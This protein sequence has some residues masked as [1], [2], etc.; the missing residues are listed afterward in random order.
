MNNRVSSGGAT[1]VSG[2]HWSRGGRE[3]SLVFSGTGSVKL[4][5]QEELG[6]GFV[7]TDNADGLREDSQSHPLSS[8]WSGL[9]HQTRRGSLSRAFV[10][11]RNI[12]PKVAME[13]GTNA[14]AGVVIFP[15]S[16]QHPARTSVSDQ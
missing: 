16:Q 8:G 15:T 4:I 12:S 14:G 10:D 3:R 9:E 11:P 6:D 5:K 7:N 13:K 1:S 2:W